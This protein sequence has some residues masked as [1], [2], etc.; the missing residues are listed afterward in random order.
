MITGSTVNPLRSLRLSKREP[1]IP[2][3]DDESLS[4]LL[5][6]Q[7]EIEETIAMSRT[8]LA[9]STKSH[10]RGTDQSSLDKNWFEFQEPE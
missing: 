5:E 6:F 9:R 10:L 3:F 2:A 4:H 7:C 8:T 1:E